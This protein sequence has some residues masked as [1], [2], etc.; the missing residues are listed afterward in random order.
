MAIWVVE[1]SGEGYQNSRVL[2]KN[3]HSYRKILTLYQL[4]YWEIVNK[5]QNLTYRVNFH[6]TL[7][8]K[9][10]S[11]TCICKIQ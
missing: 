2:A 1:F 10:M 6:F 9:V 5:C 4:T 8:S 3:Q 7:F 11:S